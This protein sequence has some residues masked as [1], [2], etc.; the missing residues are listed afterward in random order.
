MNQEHFEKRSD[1]CFQSARSVLPVI[2]ALFIER[3]K[4]AIS[5]G[6]ILRD[7]KAEE[8]LER[9]LFNLLDFKYIK[10]E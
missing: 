7:I 5:L 3:L 9:I 10:E 1:L 6:G 2:E 8:K 4:N